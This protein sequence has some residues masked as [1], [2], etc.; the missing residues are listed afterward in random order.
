VYLAG[1]VAVPA[2]ADLGTWPLISAALAAGIVATLWNVLETIK[3][4]PY[5]RG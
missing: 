1:L 4:V 2:L 3:T 5:N